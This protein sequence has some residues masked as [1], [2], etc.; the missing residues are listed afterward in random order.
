MILVDTSIW[1]DHLSRGTSSLMDLLNEGLVA[2]HPCV[3]GELACGRLR[4]RAE[5]LGLLAALPQ[6]R[7]AEH[8]EL[9]GLI[10]RHRLFGRGLGWVDIHLLGGAY[11]STCTLWTSDKA[12]HEAARRLGIAADVEGAR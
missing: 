8:D 5:I 2:C 4:K 1:V 3:I 9:L 10:D 6:A 12:L 7:V 11:L